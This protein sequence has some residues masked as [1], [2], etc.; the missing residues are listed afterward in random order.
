M[1]YIYDILLNFNERLIEFFEWEDYDDIKYIRKIP[2][3]NVDSN[4]IKDFINYD[5][6]V[7]DDFL[8]MINKKANFYDEEFDGYENIALVCDGKMA[9]GVRIDNNMVTMVSRLLLCEE[10]D[11]IRVV[12]RIPK[13]LISYE[14]MGK[15]QLD[16]L[17][18]F[19][20]KEL[21]IIK[22]LK[23]EFTS[24]YE[25]HQ[26]EKLNYYYYEYFKEHSNDIEYVYKTLIDSINNDFN[27]K[28]IMLYEIIKLSY[29]NNYNV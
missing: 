21:K 5:V 19:T 7:S 24:L 18:N 12:E 29:K 27:K 4:V 11:V 17:F 3:F 13:T 22:V 28:H 6:K 23:D 2:V 14:V 15:K 9:L 16:D 1:I 20:R 10:Q 25:Q 26:V 8:L